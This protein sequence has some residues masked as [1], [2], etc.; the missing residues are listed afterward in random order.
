MGGF[1][2]WDGGLDIFLKTVVVV[3]TA[4]CA[5]CVFLRKILIQLTHKNTQS[6]MKPVLAAALALSAFTLSS[7]QAV[8]LLTN[9][10]FEA[11]SLAGWTTFNQAGGNGNFF[12]D[13]PGT[14]TPSSSFATAPN[15]SGGA[16][17]AVTDQ[18]GAGTHAIL[19]TFVISAPGSTVIVSFQ[20]FVNS[21]SA[22][23]AI[24]PAGLD[25]TA[26]PNQHARVDILS[27]AAAPLDTG[28]GVLDNL[29]IGVDAGPNPHAYTPYS[30][31]I[32]SFVATP[33]TYQL[34]FAESDNSG[35]LHLGVDNVSVAVTV[36]EPASVSF[37]ALAL[38]GM[39][40]GWRPK[41][42]ARA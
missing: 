40:A 25:Y 6:P 13:A 2:R 20:M 17:Y 26:S 4:F 31:D 28:A 30:F 34:R 8:E 19:Q 36:P 3:M 10:N 37:L 16:F 21:E 41:N 27:G 29:F 18:G 24:N 9:G 11:G 1:G 14:T 38:S 12:I 39:L 35:F 42:R 5:L 23:L 7:A 32:T 15:A 22:P 33:G